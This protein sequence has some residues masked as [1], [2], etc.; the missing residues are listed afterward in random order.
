ML[1]RIIKSCAIKSHVIEKLII[2]KSQSQ[3]HK[4]NYGSIM[5]FFLMYHYILLFIN[6]VLYYIS[7]P[8]LHIENPFCDFVIVIV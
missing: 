1:G 7:I 8:F 2:T 3:N 6:K 5:L 4:I